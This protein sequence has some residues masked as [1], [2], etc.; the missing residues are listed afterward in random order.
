PIAEVVHWY[1]THGYDFIVLTDHNQVSELEPGNDTRG[2]P[3]ILERPG[4]I[5]LAGIELTYNPTDCIPKGDA[6]RRCRIHVNMIGATSRPGGKIDWADRK[7]H[8]RVEKY[9]SAIVAGSMLGGI[10]QMNHPNW[11]WGTTV[12]VLV[13]VARRGMRLVEIANAQFPKWNAGDKDHPG[14]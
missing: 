10:A 1:E 6:S 8:D 9:Q 12:D 5:V 4:M 13:G 3:A 14:I 7:T 11:Y 2:K